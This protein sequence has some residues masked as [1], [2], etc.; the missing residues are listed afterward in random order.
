MGK[1][2]VII[3]RFQVD[4]LHDGHTVLIDYVNKNND[5]LII[6]IGLSPLKCTYN[7]P[8]DFS[9][10]KKMLEET[11]PDAII[12][13]I[14]DEISDKE[15][16]EKLDKMLKKIPN[17]DDEICLYGSRDSF[18]KHY[19]G[20]YKTEE[21]EQTVFTSGTNV[22]KEIAGSVVSNADFRK[23]VIWAAMNQYTGP[24]T[25]IDVAILNDDETKVLL[26]KKPNED[27]LRFIGGFAESGESFE[28]TAYREADEET[29]LALMDLRYIKS[30]PVDDWRYKNEK[31]K[32]TT[33]FFKANILSGKPM[34]GDDIVELMWVN[35][36]TDLGYVIIDVHKP[37]AQALLYSL[38]FVTSLTDIINKNP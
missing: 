33:L 15:W 1:T 11:Y 19:H 21:L 22:R 28:Q 10:V 9:A 38:G 18:I 37:L 16:S 30:I 32:I 13:Y 5:E 27:K 23:G 12:M 6:F 8:L 25:T 29:N 20:E 17:P 36:E 4:E 31:K 3:G 7:N 34:P 14:K 24:A 2:G 26:G 35:I